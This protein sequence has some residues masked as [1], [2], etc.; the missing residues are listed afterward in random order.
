MKAARSFARNI[1]S[2]NRRAVAK[3]DC[4]SLFIG[5][6]AARRVVEAGRHD[7]RVEGAFRGKR[8]HL[9]P[10]A[11]HG[12][13]ELR[14]PAAGNQLVVL[15]EA[16]LERLAVGAVVLRKFIE[17]CEFENRAVDA[18]LVGKTL[19]ETLHVVEFFERL[20]VPDDAEG[21]RSRAYCAFRLRS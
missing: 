20:F 2:R 13:I 8:L 10:G 21:R 17:R 16:F 18:V 5:A 7:H 15:D 9:A 14:V 19:L 1:E 6:D 4:L 12:L 3:A 11:L